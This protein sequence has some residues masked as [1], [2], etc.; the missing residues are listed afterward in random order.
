MFQLNGDRLCPWDYFEAVAVI[1]V[2]VIELIEVCIHK[3]TPALLTAETA[4]VHS[5][6]PTVYLH[7]TLDQHTVLLYHPIHTDSPHT[8]PIAVLVVR[9]S[10]PSVQI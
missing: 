10:T 3:P 9:L 1:V 4:V 6:H 2:E 5:V 8:L 7:P